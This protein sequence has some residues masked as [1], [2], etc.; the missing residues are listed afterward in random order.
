MKK[1]FIMAA[2]IAAVG[3]FAC[4]NTPKKAESQPIVTTGAKPFGAAITANGAVGYDEMLEKTKTLSKDSLAIKVVGK[5]ESVC[6]MK[7][8]WMNVVSET[9]GKD[10]M[11]VQFKDYGFFMPKDIA[12]KKVIFEGFAYREETSVDDLRHYAEDEHKSKA[13]IEAITKP[14]SELKFLASGVLLLE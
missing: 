12:G 9:A 13:E 10:T 5:V 8:C 11:F 2:A 3:L 1:S 4:Q 14:K 6:Q 7:G